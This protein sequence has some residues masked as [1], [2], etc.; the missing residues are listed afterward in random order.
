MNNVIQNHQIRLQQ[1]YEQSQTIINTQQHLPND[2][3]QLQSCIKQMQYHCLELLHLQYPGCLLSFPYMPSSDLEHLSYRHQQSDASSGDSEHSSSSMDE[4]E[5]SPVHCD[6]DQ[7]SMDDRLTIETCH[8][9]VEY[10][11]K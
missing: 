2:Q 5:C 3:S 8:G 1:L 11:S 4:N 7:P 6:N 9:L 10:C